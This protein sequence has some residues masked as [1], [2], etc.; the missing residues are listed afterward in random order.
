MPELGLDG[1]AFA[2]PGVD[3]RGGDAESAIAASAP[4][5]RWLEA[6]EPGVRLRSLSVNLRTMRVLVTLET[7]DKPRVLRFDP[8]QSAELV[9]LAAGAARIIDE[10]CALRLASRA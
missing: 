1:C 2:G 10:A 8:P 7:G 3:L 5:A 4:I 6:R 9:A